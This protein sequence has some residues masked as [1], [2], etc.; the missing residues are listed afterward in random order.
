MQA[1]DLGTQ[2]INLVPPTD[3]PREVIVAR[4]IMT[5][6]AQVWD[7]SDPDSSKV[8]RVGISFFD[9]GD[10]AWI[11]EGEGRLIPQPSTLEALRRRF[12][13]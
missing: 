11:R 8:V 6:M 12:T 5:R 7:D 2:E 13:L 3:E 9:A 10:R 1:F 4:D